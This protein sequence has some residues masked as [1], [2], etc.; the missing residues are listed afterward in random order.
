MNIG[1]ETRLSRAWFQNLRRLRAPVANAA[2]DARR[3]FHRHTPAACIDRQSLC[4]RLPV[5]LKLVGPFPKAEIIAIDVSAPCLRYAH[6]RAEALEKTVH[7]AQ[8]NAEHTNF[9]DE[10]FDLI[11]SHILFHETSRQAVGNFMKECF[12]L[13]KPGGLAVHVDV[14]RHLTEKTPFD[15]FMGDWDT[16]HNNEPFWGTLLFDMDMIDLA[17]ASG[18]NRDNVQETVADAGMGNMH[19]WVYAARK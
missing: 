2:H 15:Q 1:I 11:V 3:R 10:S 16:L 4:D 14:A 19:Y 9:D 17:V 18:F 13:L 12:R 8:Q 6:A 5:L 7:F